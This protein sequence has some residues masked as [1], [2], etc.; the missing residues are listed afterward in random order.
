MANA[1]VKLP[2]GVTRVVDERM[3]AELDLLIRAYFI[4]APESEESDISD[5]MEIMLVV[6][7]RL[8]SIEMIMLGQA[9]SRM[10]PLVGQYYLISKQMGISREDFA[11]A[12]CDAFKAVIKEAVARAR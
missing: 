7:N 8:N 4:E 12:F 5:L 3:R 6:K 9:T 10:T 11:N 2:E 1:G